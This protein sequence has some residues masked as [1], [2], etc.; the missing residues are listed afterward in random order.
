MQH[1]D[2]TRAELTGYA[3]GGERKE[4]ICPICL[5]PCENVYRDPLNAIVGCNVCLSVDYDW[6]DWD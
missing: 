3:D 4:H 2:I 5:E 6:D 1:P